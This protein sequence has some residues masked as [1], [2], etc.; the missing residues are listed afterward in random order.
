MTAPAPGGGVTGRGDAGGVVRAALKE[1]RARRRIRLAVESRGYKL[2]SLEWEPWSNGGEKSGICGGWFGLLD[3][4]YEPNT[5]PGNEIMGLST[6]EVVAW[7]DEFV[8]PPEPCECPPIGYP[9]AFQSMEPLWRHKPECRW[10]LRYW[11][12]WWMS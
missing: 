4:S 7:V 11:M 2:V 12:R 10:H 1:T 6:D 3:R 9:G 5:F 8:P